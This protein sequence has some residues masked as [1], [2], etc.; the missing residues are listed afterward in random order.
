MLIL[1][2][3]LN[4]HIIIGDEIRVYYLGLSM[5]RQ[6]RFGIEAPSDLSIHRAEIYDLIKQEELE[7]NQKSNKINDFKGGY[8]YRT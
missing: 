1:T 4:E 2:R 5:Q 6:A 7:K 3:R 8:R